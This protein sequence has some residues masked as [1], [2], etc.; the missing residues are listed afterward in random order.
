MEYKE[1][2]IREFV[3][4][5]GQWQGIHHNAR[6]L[7]ERGNQELQKRQSTREGFSAAKS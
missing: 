3:N 2:L 7:G 5:K 4:D 1:Y 6:R